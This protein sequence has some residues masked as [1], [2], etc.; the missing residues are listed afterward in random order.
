MPT[1]V[2]TERNPKTCERCGRAVCPKVESP[3][4]LRPG[5]MR[6]LNYWACLLGVSAYTVAREFA[7]DIKTVRSRRL[8]SRKAIE[9]RY[10]G[11]MDAGS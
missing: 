5:Q 11:I 1:T 10:P 6:P 7:D 4:R 9:R 3:A 8:V 2:N